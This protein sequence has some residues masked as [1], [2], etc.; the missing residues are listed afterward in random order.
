MLGT[1]PEERRRR[2]SKTTL[3]HIAPGVGLSSTVIVDGDEIEGQPQRT[4]YIPLTE[5][6]D[7]AYETY[8]YYEDRRA[9]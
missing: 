5:G 4:M 6:E 9:G 8:T 3:D 1:R 2:G 7:V